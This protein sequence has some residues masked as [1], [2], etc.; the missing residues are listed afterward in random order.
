MP[1]AGCGANLSQ[2][3]SPIAPSRY[4]CNDV[5]ITEDQLVQETPFEYGILKIEVS[6]YSSDSF[7]DSFEL[8]VESQN[9]LRSHI[10]EIAPFVG[11]SLSAGWLP[12]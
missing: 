6:D 7:F 2:Y 5:V 12:G 10:Y 1:M 8:S 11:P 4:I 3:S 9:S